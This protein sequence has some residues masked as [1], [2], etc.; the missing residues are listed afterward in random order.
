MTNIFRVLLVSICLVLE[1]T[2]VYLLLTSDSRK[3][4][5]S[6]VVY[7]YYP[8][9]LYLLR[10]ARPRSSLDFENRVWRR[11]RRQRRQRRR[12]MVV[13]P[14]QGAHAAPVAPLLSL[15]TFFLYQTLAR[16]FSK[17]RTSQLS[18][19]FSTKNKFFWMCFLMNSISETFSKIMPKFSQD[20]IHCVWN[21]VEGIFLILGFE[22][23]IISIEY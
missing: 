15:V 9:A 18:L 1:L 14:S 17:S 11:Q 16:S 13:L 19:S 21:R 8:G 22:N 4:L 12:V 23:T 20:I 7:H 10:T 3:R 5:P 6:T 2:G